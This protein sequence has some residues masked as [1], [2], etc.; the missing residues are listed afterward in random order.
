MQEL[1]VAQ[2]TIVGTKE[3]LQEKTNELNLLN[4]ETS[5]NYL[6]TAELLF[7]IR[8]SRLWKLVS[9]TF[10]EYVETHLENETGPRA[11]FLCE[12]WDFVR[13]NLPDTKDREKLLKIGWRKMVELKK[14]ANKDNIVEWLDKASGETL[15][16]LTEDVRAAKED[17]PA[18]VTTPRMFS[19]YPEQKKTVD[20]AIEIAQKAGK[21]KS[22]SRALELM[23]LEF[24]ANRIPQDNVDELTSMLFK[25]EERFGVFLVAIDKQNGDVKYGREEAFSTL[26]AKL[27]QINKKA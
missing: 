11:R 19:L 27:S 25:L 4:Q 12:I 13:V 9:K 17:R 8:E 2:E 21:T 10:E 16:Q 7:E 26:E 20:E 5:K 6:R 18:E 24:M 1:T 3:Q 23:S 22:P 14:V 15:L